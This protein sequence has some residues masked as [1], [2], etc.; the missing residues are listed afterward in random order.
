MSS[1]G[2]AAPLTGPST[3][4]L[5]TPGTSGLGVRRSGRN[6]TSAWMAVQLLE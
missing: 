4:P 2:A 1:S 6:G 3:M 5:I